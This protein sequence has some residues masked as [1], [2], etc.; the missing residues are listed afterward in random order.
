MTRRFGLF[1]QVTGDQKP[2]RT[3]RPRRCGFEG[4]AIPLG[5][6]CSGTASNTRRRSRNTPPAIAKLQEAIPL[7]R[8]VED[9]KLI[10]SCLDNIGYAAISKGNEAEGLRNYSEALKLA[11]HRQDDV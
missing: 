9:Q 11:E 5:A 1:G 3:F 4:A 2:L 8:L 7:A 6:T 10:G